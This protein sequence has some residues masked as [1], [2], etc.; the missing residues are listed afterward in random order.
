VVLVQYNLKEMLSYDPNTGNIFWKINPNLGYTK[1][2]D[3]AG[4]IDNKGYIVISVGYK[5]YKAHR[6]A[7]YLYYDEWPKNQI[8]HIDR[9]K[10]N[11]CINNLRDVTQEINQSNS[12]VRKD[13]TSGYRGISWNKIRKKWQ[14]RIQINGKRK[15]LGFFDDINKAIERRLEHENNIKY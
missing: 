11:N 12:H 2:G 13:S 7:W 8:D 3:I 10:Q 14:V 9:N 6:L 4:T 5:R 15:E 1:A